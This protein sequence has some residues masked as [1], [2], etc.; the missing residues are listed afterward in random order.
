[1]QEKIISGLSEGWWMFF[2]TFWALVLGFT[3]SGVVQAFVTRKSMESALGKRD[4]RTIGKASFFGM[5]SSSCSYAASALGRSIFI[6]GADFTTS[7]VFM[8]AS[9]NLVIE[10]GIVLWLML[11]W[12]FA[13]AEFVGGAIMII[14][15][16]LTLPRVISSKLI[17]QVRSDELAKDG[18]NDAFMAPPVGMTM[19]SMA[20]SAIDS[21]INSVM[22]TT[23]IDESNGASKWSHKKNWIS[24]AGYTMGDFIMLR[25]ELVIGFIVAGLAATVVPFSFWQSLFISNH[26]FLSALENAIIGPFLAFISFVC[27]VGNVPLAAALWHA[28]ITFGGVV[29]FIFA[30]LLAF[31][32]VMIYRK[33]YGN[34]IALRMSFLFW[35]IMST[36]GLITQGIFSL[37]KL[38]PSDSHRNMSMSRIGWNCTTILDALFLVVFLVVY[39]L[40]KSRNVEDDSEFAQDPICG[41]QVRKEDAPAS[42]EYESKMYYFCMDGCK[43][44]FLKEKASR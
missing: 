16:A 11:G 4:A 9:T 44:G 36:S 30:D 17:N 34:K 15:L 43:E 25:K 33:Y 32:L 19:L 42:T 41:M 3:L 2:H 38:V 37:L 18:K 12:Q 35:A 13:V 26:G 29:A 40:Y 28:G 24:A 21:D 5:V 23:S 7:M 8:F 6:K 39:A 22:G 10:L 20:D 31:P 27:S 1:M 14:L